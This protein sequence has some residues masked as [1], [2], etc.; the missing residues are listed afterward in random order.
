M[1]DNKKCDRFS[2]DTLA[3]LNVNV[4]GHLISSIKILINKLFNKFNFD[5]NIIN[6]INQKS[7]H[8]KLIEIF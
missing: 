8:N 2:M 5:S 1:S 6:C 4:H 3:I 7:I